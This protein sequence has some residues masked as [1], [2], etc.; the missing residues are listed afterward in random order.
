MRQITKTYTLY[1]YEDLM[2]EENLTIKEAVLKKRREYIQEMDIFERCVAEPTIEKWVEKLSEIGFV[3]PRIMYSIMYSGFYS[4]GDGACFDC[5]Y[6]DWLTFL[7]SHEITITKEIELMYHI[8]PHDLCLKVYK[9]DFANHY[10]NGGTRYVSASAHANYENQD[11]HMAVTSFI[12][13]LNWKRAEYCTEIYRE[14]QK[15]YEEL[16]KDEII[17]QEIKECNLEFYENGEF[18]MEL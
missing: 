4:Q 14:L 7:N 3:N 10:N 1:C 8:S 9:N 18:Y 6:I 17:L 2:Q 13:L 12:Q 16:Q 11:L 15:G 5:D